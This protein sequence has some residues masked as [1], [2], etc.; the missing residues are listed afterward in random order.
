MS[1]EAPGGPLE[2]EARYY[3]RI[4]PELLK[5]RKGKFAL[6]KGEKLIGTFDTDLDAYNAGLKELGNEPF[7]I[8][9]VLEVNPH[10]W[11]PIVQLGLINAS[12][13]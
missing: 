9:Q 1:D 7:L 4:K 2:T 6:I 10:P 5:D 3:A 8:I 13:Q 12:R 11:I